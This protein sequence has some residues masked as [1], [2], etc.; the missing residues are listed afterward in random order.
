MLVGV[1]VGGRV[2][3]VGVGVTG[4][5]LGVRVGV[6]VEG[7][8][9]KVEVGVTGEMPGAKVGVGVEVGVSVGSSTDSPLTVTNEV[10]AEP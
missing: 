9:V 10:A 6:G 8:G 1:L 7:W 4:R 5:M 2:V 3:K